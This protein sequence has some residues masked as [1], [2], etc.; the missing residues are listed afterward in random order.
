M[1]PRHFRAHI[2]YHHVDLDIIY[3]LWLPETYLTYGIMCLS[4]SLNLTSCSLLKLRK[5]ELKT[6]RGMNDKITMGSLGS[7]IESFTVS[8]STDSNESIQSRR[9]VKCSEDHSSTHL[10]NNI[11]FCLFL[12]NF[13]QMHIHS[14]VFFVLNQSILDLSV[15]SL[16]LQNLVFFLL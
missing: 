12:T 14:Q 6:G 15:M 8:D 2:A 16:Y 4:K 3:W 10:I 11:W 9:S 7:V 13:E 5:K 1:I